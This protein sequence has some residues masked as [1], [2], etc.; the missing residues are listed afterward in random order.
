MTERIRHFA[1]IS[2]DWEEVDIGDRYRKFISSFHDFGNN[3][4][5]KIWTP[6]EIKDLI[7]K[8]GFSSLSND[9][10]YFIQSL[11]LF[12]YLAVYDQGGFWADADI[13]CRKNIDFLFSNSKAFAA[14]QNPT[15]RT[16]CTAFLGAPS[17]HPAILAVIESFEPTWK[18]IKENKPK[19]KQ[20]LVVKS[21]APEFTK[22]FKRRK[23]TICYNMEYFYPFDWNV[24]NPNPNDY[25]NAYMVHYWDKSWWKLNK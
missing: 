20:S 16:L 11:D 14:Y 4:Q 15:N 19:T 24:K 3:L 21:S 22:I 10:D 2:P 8:Y 7:E 13:E 9:Y 18:K 17:R 12:K 25:P 23:D 1:F 5:T 6:K